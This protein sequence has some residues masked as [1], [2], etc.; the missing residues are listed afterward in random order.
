MDD[1][2]LL[3]IFDNLDLRDL[4]N[5]AGINERI[6]RFIQ[7]HYIIGKNRMHEKSLIIKG[8]IGEYFIAGALYQKIVNNIDGILRFLRYFGSAPRKIDIFCTHDTDS[9]FIKLGQYIE[10]YCHDTLASINFKGKAASLIN[11]W[12]VPFNNVAHIE[13]ILTD[14]LYNLPRIFP[15]IQTLNITVQQHISSLNSSDLSKL[16]FSKLNELKYSEFGTFS[17]FTLLKQILRLNPQLRTFRT[18]D[19]LDIEIVT[20]L[21]ENAPNLHC[22]EINS[23]SHDFIDNIMGSAIIPFRT[24]EYLTLKFFGS[25]EVV[26]N[27]FPIAFEQLESL[28]LSSYSVPSELLRFITENK[29]LQRLSLE[30]APLNRAQLVEVFNGL[31]ELLYF[32]VRW[33]NRITSNE[34]FEAI[35]QAPLLNTVKINPDN[36]INVD[37]FVKGMVG[38]EW[39]LIGTIDEWSKQMSFQRI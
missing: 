20:F 9:E 6:D 33:C 3:D 18:L 31:P 25:G 4:I 30:W 29:R 17:N 39:K 8:I 19:T 22:L 15:N 26:E 21:A 16:T 12:N 36:E 38:G 32:E 2:S 10:R 37:A 14:E 1:Y 24:V 35:Q 27:P 11:R 13:I 5:L 28:D 23:Y 7:H 34:L